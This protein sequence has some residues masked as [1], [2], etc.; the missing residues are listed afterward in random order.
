MLGIRTKILGLILAATLIPLLLLNFYWTNSERQS[1]INGTRSRQTLIAQSDAEKVSDFLDEKIRTLIIHSQSPSLQQ[2]NLSQSKLAMST[3]LYQDSDLT[4]AALVDQNGQEVIALNNKLQAVSLQNVKNND[5]FKVVNY[6]GGNEYISPV[7]ND[8]NGQPTITIAVPLVTFTTPQELGSLSTSEPGVVR[9]PKDIKG[10][11][12]VQ[13]SLE[14]LWSSVLST[15]NNANN[16]STPGDGYAYVV[17]DKGLVIAHPDSSLTNQHKDLSGTPIVSLFKNNLGSTGSTPQSLEGK[18][19][20]GVAVLSTYQKVPLTNWA[21]VFEEPMSS[22]YKNVSHVSTLGI[23]ISAVAIVILAA[24]SFWLSRYITRP[25]LQIATIARRMGRGDF[26]QQLTLNRSDEIGQLGDSINAMGKNLHEFIGRIQSQRKQLEAILNNTTDGIM[27]LN[28]DGAILIANQAAANLCEIDSTLLVGRSIGET[29][30]WSQSSRPFIVNYNAQGTKTYY[31]L[32]YTSPSGV[33]HFVNLIVVKMNS[34]DANAQTIVTIHDETKNRELED[35][36]IDF[37]S[38]AAHELRTPL[39]AIR[40]YL[41]LIMF[42]P[43]ENMDEKVLKYATQARTSA[44]ILATLI[45][46]LLDVSRIERGTL[47]LTMDK[48]DLADTVNQA[49]QNLSFNAQDKQITLQYDGPTRECYV[50]ADNIA[51]KEVVGNLLDNAIKYTQNGGKVDV[52]LIQKD[53]NYVVTVSDTGVGIP[54]NSLPYLF[55]KFYRVHG[56]LESGSSGTGLGLYI[57]KSIMERHSGTITVKS[58]E[59][60]GSVFTITIPIFTEEK[61]AQVRDAKGT[62]NVSRRR[63]WT[64]KNIA[65]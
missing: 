8:S 65:R 14:S 4:R 49:V 39:S 34:S 13:A 31:D 60:K 57:S 37:V 16:V 41:E 10:A 6:F 17:N 50:V 61:F 19:E 1:L 30:R 55:T 44:T 2:F 29:L 46:N 36:K 20:K 28:S 58:N 27:A 23:A 62:D 24:L 56:G 25:I 26:S 21:V 42:Q 15:K 45:S 33:V 12:I 48:V 54:A 3:L 59:G 43:K 5:A 47:V 53:D 52:G 51:I 11:L 40:G 22:I 63:G 35:M 38:M 18:S 64:T 7:T 9:N 32:Q